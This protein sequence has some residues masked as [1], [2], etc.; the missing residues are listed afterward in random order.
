[1]EGRKRPAV[2]KMVLL[3]YPFQNKTN[4]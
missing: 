3:S 2:E 1:V 4:H